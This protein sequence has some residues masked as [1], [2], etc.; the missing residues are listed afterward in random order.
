MFISMKK[1]SDNTGESLIVDP[2]KTDTDWC[3]LYNEQIWITIP[4]K[5]DNLSSRDKMRESKFGS[6]SIISSEVSLYGVHYKFYLL[7]ES[8]SLR[9]LPSLKKYNL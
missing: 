4:P 5:E 9:H 7:V 6:E 2:P 1:T 8:Y 3:S